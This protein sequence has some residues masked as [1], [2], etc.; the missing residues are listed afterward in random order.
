MEKIDSLLVFLSVVFIG[1]L[2]SLLGTYKEYEGA[3]SVLL[4]TISV[5][6][7]ILASFEFFR[8]K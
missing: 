3:V 1:L 8:K 7:F 5:A 2:V 6:G 4:T